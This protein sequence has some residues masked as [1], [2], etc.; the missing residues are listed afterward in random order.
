LPKSLFRESNK[1]VRALLLAAGKG[2]RLQPLT[3]YWPKCLM[4]IAGRP[5][6]EYWLKILHDLGIKDVLVNTHS[7][8]DHVE[9]FLARKQFS[10]WVKPVFEKKLLGTAGTIRKNTYFFSG[11]TMFLAHADNWCQCDFSEFINYHLYERPSHC[12]ITMMTFTTNTPQSCGIV[13]T[14]NEGV[15]CGFH[16]KVSKPPGNKA[17]GA[18][19]LI[20]PEVIEWLKIHNGVTDFSTEVITEF[21]GHIATWHNNN[22]HRDIGTINSLRYAQH[23][24]IQDYDWPVRDEW[25]ENFCKTSVFKRIMYH[26]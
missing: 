16:E 26:L 5:L 22:I 23:D 24:I 2:T 1:I 4:P 19:Y 10:N 17:N 15:V 12:S 14:N 7:H 8:K 3:N 18:I 9:T 6:L 21:I 25:G 11:H 20:E 13:E